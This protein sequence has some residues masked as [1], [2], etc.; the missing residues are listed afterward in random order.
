MKLAK[1]A[2]ATM[3][4]AAF[5]ACGQQQYSY[6]NVVNT[7]I[8]DANP[9]GLASTIDVSGVAGAVSNVTVFVNVTGAWNG[10]LYAYLSYDGG[11][12]AVLMNR[13]GK[14]DSD[15]TGYSDTGFTVTFS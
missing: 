10:D 3:V 12:Y 7:T 13:V 2:S 4:L 15:P 11:G 6:T 5:S 9:T 8:P 14:T 1:I